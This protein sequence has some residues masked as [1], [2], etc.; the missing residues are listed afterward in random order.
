MNKFFVVIGIILLMVGIVVAAFMP[1]WLDQASEIINPGEFGKNI[2]FSVG[3]VRNEFLQEPAISN[4]G[5]SAQP[6]SSL[7]TLDSRV[8]ITI[9][10]SQGF[11][12]IIYTNTWTNYPDGNDDEVLHSGY[13]YLKYGFYSVDFQ[14]ENRGGELCFPFGCDWAASQ[15]TNGHL[16]RDI[17]VSQSGVRVVV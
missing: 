14:L 11:E 12:R 16:T 17:E 4:V 7:S 5:V 13:T 8:R 3:V 10:N 9:R 15:H 1:E 6:L 2:M